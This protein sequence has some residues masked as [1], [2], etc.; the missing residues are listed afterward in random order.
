MAYF[1]KLYKK[2]AHAYFLERKSQKEICKEFGIS[3]RTLSRW[4]QKPEFCAYIE[5]L[6][7]GAIREAKRIL[8]ANVKGAAT[9]LVKLLY[10]GTPKDDVKRKAAE[11]IL[12]RIEGLEKRLAQTQTVSTSINLDPKGL[13]LYH[14]LSEEERKQVVRAVMPILEYVREKAREVKR[15]SQTAGGKNH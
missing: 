6:E 10:H 1:D 8:L 9:Q 13:D 7:E 2:V 5:A 11:S 15:Q 12:N 4:L 3:R 14:K